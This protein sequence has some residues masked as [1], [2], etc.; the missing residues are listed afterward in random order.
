MPRPTHGVEALLNALG[1]IGVTL[2]IWSYIFLQTPGGAFNSQGGMQITLF[3]FPLALLGW[4]SLGVRGIQLGV[5]AATDPTAK[6]RD[7]LAVVAAV[8]VGAL[9]GLLMLG[10]CVAP[11]ALALTLLAH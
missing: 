2:G 8:I 3:L 1:S 10:T 6:P 4:V 11:E 7:R 5:R 9:G